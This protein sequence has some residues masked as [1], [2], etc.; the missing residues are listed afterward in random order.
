MAGSPIDILQ[1]Y[2]TAAKEAL[3]LSFA[4]KVRRES[5]CSKA[6][7]SLLGQVFLC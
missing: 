6:K 4:L 5:S 7:I 3:D 2:L 1:A